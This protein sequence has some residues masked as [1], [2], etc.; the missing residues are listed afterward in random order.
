MNV[1]VRPHRVERGTNDVSLNVCPKMRKMV[2]FSSAHFSSSYE[3]AAFSSGAAF[4]AC[5][6]RNC[7]M[8]IS[9]LFAYHFASGR[10]LSTTRQKNLQ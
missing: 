9:L 5:I 7:P 2:V 3:N 8:L 1:L 4:P 10:V 6:F